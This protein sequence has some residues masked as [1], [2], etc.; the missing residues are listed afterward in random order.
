M[1]RTGWGLGFRGW[2]VAM[3]ARI[4]SLRSAVCLLRAVMCR[5]TAQPERGRMSWDAG[6]EESLHLGL[7]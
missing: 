2:G 3:V 7:A 6:T 4:A 5:S 1:T